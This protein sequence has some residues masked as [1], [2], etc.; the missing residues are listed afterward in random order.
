MG[1]SIRDLILS[2]RREGDNAKVP[3]KTDANGALIVQGAGAEPTAAA[4]KIADGVDPAR[5]ATVNIDGE[6]LV[7]ASPA[8]GSAT[9]SKQDTQI[10]HLEALAAEDFATEATLGLLLAET[11]DIDN[12]V[13]S[14]VTDPVPA[15]P[16]GG[17]GVRGWLSAIWTK[18]NAGLT[19]EGTV[20][21][22]N[23][24]YPLPTGQVTTLTPQTD[25]LTDAQLRAQ[26]VPVAA[27]RGPVTDRS[28]SIAEGGTSQQVMAANPARSYL[29]IVNQST[30]VMWIDFGSAAVAGQP[31]VRLR[32]DD[33]FVMEAGFVATDAVHVLCS[34]TGAEYVAKEG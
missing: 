13:G 29:L 32:A 10:T 23:P 34:D 14:D 30:A 25:V 5:L 1:L 20:A 3:L 22:S 26:P 31:S 12:G 33:T 9:E 16:V 27:V 2:A 15:M 17:S 6:L 18:L 8:E 7:K 19:V 4:L 24:S 21:V 11:A 28:G